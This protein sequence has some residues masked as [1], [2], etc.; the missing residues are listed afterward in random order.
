MNSFNEIEDLQEY[1]RDNYFLENFYK[2]NGIVFEKQPPDLDGSYAY[3]Y[4]EDQ[5][6]LLSISKINALDYC[7]N[8]V[9]DLKPYF[10]APKY[11]AD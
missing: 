6:L 10:L 9:L 11:W 7:K 2:L 5:K 3:Y 1:I 8:I 4:N